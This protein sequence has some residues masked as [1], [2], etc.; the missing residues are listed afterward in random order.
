[1]RYGD[2]EGL[3]VIY[4]ADGTIIL[5]TDEK[6][7][8]RERGIIPTLKTTWRVYGGETLMSTIKG[9][10][11]LTTDRLVFIGEREDVYLI[12]KEGAR[13]AEEPRGLGLRSLTT[14]GVRDFF[15]IPNLEIMGVERKSGVILS[16]ELTYIYL[17]SQGKQYHIQMTLR[18]ASPLLKRLLNKEV[19]SVDHLVKNLKKYFQITD[20]MYTESEK[21]AWRDVIER[22]R[23]EADRLGVEQGIISGGE[24]VVDTRPVRPTKEEAKKIDGLTVEYFRKLLE[25]G[26]IT[27]KIY[28]K[29]TGEKAPEVTKEEIPEAEEAPAAPSI[30]PP[31]G[32]APEEVLPEKMRKPEVE[33]EVSIPIQIPHGAGVP[34]PDA[35]GPEMAKEE[36]AETP[37]ERSRTLPSPPPP[38]GEEGAM[39]T[40]SAGDLTVSPPMPAAG[41]AGEGTPTEGVSEEGL[42][43][44]LKDELEKMLLETLELAGE[45]ERDLPPPP[46]PV[47]IEGPGVWAGEA[48]LGKGKS[49]E[50][51]Q[52]G[53]L[54]EGQIPLGPVSGEVETPKEEAPPR[55]APKKVKA[56][57]II[58]KVKKPRKE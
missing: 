21:A 2:K 9:D 19:P 47:K 32:G 40:S 17:L 16:G 35:R 29:L 15:E 39:P 34:S 54:E 8:A 52:T 53:A 45:S 13:V 12:G 1:M 44:P 41:E 58:L 26:L 3:G 51:L 25:K 46:P 18:S 55:A 5:E 20:W 22:K 14:S 6:V 10:I 48:G 49:P 50:Q 7:L 36:S 43:P 38:A 56:K 28:E 37:P 42:A 24:V 23:A 11:Y 27:P 57:K 33:E 31:P 30:G 4:N